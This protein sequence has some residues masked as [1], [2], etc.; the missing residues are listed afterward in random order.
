[1]R[2]FELAQAYGRDARTAAAVKADWLADRDFVGD[3]QLGFAYVNLS[4]IPKPCTVNLRY[5]GNTLVC[6]VK[7]A[8]DARPSDPLAWIAGAKPRA[9]YGQRTGNARKA[10]SDAARERARIARDL[11]YEGSADFQRDLED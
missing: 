10:E 7:V 6:V 8:A 4:S 3:F 1:M 9:V 11:T 2:Y 5:R